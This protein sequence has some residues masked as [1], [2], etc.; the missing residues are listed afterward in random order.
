MWACKN[1]D[2]FLHSCSIVLSFTLFIQS[3]ILRH[4]YA[5]NFNHVKAFTHFMLILTIFHKFLNLDFMH[6]KKK[7]KKKKKTCNRRKTK[8]TVSFLLCPVL[9]VHVNGKP[10]AY[11]RANFV[12]VRG[13]TAK[14]LCIKVLISYSSVVI[15]SFFEIDQSH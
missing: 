8:L 10:N 13:C 9:P 3:I 2:H 6:S 4:T 15:F 14:R 12:C 5:E 1:Q 11:V 7:K